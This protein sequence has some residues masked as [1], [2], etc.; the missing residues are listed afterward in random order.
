MHGNCEN[1]PTTFTEEKCTTYNFH[2][3]EK[4]T[5]LDGDLTNDSNLEPTIKKKNQ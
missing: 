3:E 1:P 4:F 5:Y 2:P